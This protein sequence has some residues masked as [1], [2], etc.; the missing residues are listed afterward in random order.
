MDDVPR[1]D[2]VC[3]P[4]LENDA[5]ASEEVERDALLINAAVSAAVSPDSDLLVRT[6]R[7]SSQAIPAVPLFPI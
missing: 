2:P 5:F 7:S 6:A 4:I 3:A 1:L